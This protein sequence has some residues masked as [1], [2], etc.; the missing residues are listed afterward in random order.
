MGNS[1]IEGMAILKVKG[2]KQ[3]LIFDVKGVTLGDKTGRIVKMRYF[4][5]GKDV[6]AEKDLGT[7]KDIKI[8]EKKLLKGFDGKERVYTE[9]R[10]SNR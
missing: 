1:A 4:E 10:A 5:P 6:L 3:S 2:Q 9:G 7:G 8:I